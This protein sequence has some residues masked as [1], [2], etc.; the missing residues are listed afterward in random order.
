MQ[1]WSEY[2]EQGFCSGERD[3]LD[4]QKAA[5]VLDIPLKRVVFEKEYWNHVFR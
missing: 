3:F 1:N 4:A 2:D 5:N